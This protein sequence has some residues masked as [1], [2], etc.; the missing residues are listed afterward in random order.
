VKT[1]QKM[2][3]PTP[4]RVGFGP[5]NCPSTRNVVKAR[6]FLRCPIRDKVADTR[7]GPSR[8]GPRLAR[9]VKPR[10]IPPWPVSAPVALATPSALRSRRR[11][12]ARASRPEAT[13]APVA[14]SRR[15][16]R[17]PPSAAAAGAALRVRRP[18]GAQERRPKTTARSHPPRAREPRGRMSSIGVCTPSEMHC[19]PS[20]TSSA[21]T[22]SSPMPCCSPGNVVSSTF[23]RRSAA[24]TR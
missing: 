17:A 1:A 3:K 18:L 12:R 15:Q 14:S 19:A 22:I 7:P 8:A 4:F 20:G 21:S 5:Q 13:C 11:G 16:P 6:H 23:V 2:A 10:A 9:P 24:E